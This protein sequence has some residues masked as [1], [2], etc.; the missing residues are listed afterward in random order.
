MFDSFFVFFCLLWP[1]I[2]LFYSICRTLSFYFH[3]FVVFY[4]LHVFM[5]LIFKFHLSSFIPWG[6]FFHFVLFICHFYWPRF[7]S[8]SIFLSLYCSSAFYWP[9]SVSVSWRTFFHFVLFIYPFYWFVFLI[10][11]LMYFL[12]FCSVHLPFLLT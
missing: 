2:F 12:L 7:V 10:C 5:K 9:R 6:I 11:F 4:P 3:S 8:W 1:N